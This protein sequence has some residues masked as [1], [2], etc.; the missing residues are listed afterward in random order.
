MF[1]FIIIS[2]IILT[3]CGKSAEINTPEPP[4]WFLEEPQNNE[5]TLYGTGESSERNSA[6]ENAL[7]NLKEK[8]YISLSS[9]TTMQD[10]IAGKELAND[11]KKTVKIKT[12]NINIQNYKIEKTKFTDGQYYAI[13][14]VEREKI[15][16]L[17]ND[18]L[19]KK[20]QKIKPQIER[21][22]FTKNIIT[23]VQMINKINAQCTEYTELE[24]FYNALGFTMNDNFCQEII[25]EY[26]NFGTKHK[27]EIVNTNPIIHDTLS[28]VFAKKFTLLQKSNSVITYK[29]SVQTTNVDGMF[30]SGLTIDIIQFNSNDKFAKKC[31]GSSTVS[32]EKATNA[33]FELCLNQAK[34]QTFEEF[35]GL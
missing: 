33:A 8:V 24:R 2:A 32:Q 23:K 3:G 4:K 14:S 10:I 27:I 18:N 34:N 7:A 22:N 29:T 5:K 20:G 17:L 19:L 35:F 16:D 1:K 25:D 30:M 13:V 28:F 31:I 15:V 21:Y 12:P 26:N 6:I 11:Y 9:V